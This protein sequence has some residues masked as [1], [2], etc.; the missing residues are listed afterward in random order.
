M[1]EDYKYKWRYKDDE[2]PRGRCYYCRTPYAEFPDMIIS[3]KF[4]ELMNPTEHQGA[5]LLCPKCI[6]DRLDY[7]HEYL[8]QYVISKDKE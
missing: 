1:F 2:R 4:W 3:D 7:I 8:K 6:S 5:G